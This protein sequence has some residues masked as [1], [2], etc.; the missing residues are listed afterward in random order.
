MT[1]NAPS[2]KR[3]SASTEP[4][5]I[6][7]EQAGASG[8]PEPESELAAA[9]TRQPAEPEVGVAPD[10]AA[11][12]TPAK[13]RRR[14]TKSAADQAPA[15]E[16]VVASE[17]TPVA[18]EPVV[19]A[20]ADVIAE[21]ATP[22][23]AESAPA[24]SKRSRKPAA[25]AAEPAPPPVDAVA[26]PAPEPPAAKPPKAR[27]SRSAKAAAAATAAR[28]AAGTPEVVPEADVHEPQSPTLEPEQPTLEP[29]PPTLRPAVGIP[30]F[31]RPATVAA[32]EPP[33][34]VGASPTLAV[35]AAAA[36]PEPLTEPEPITGAPRT[37]FEQRLAR[38]APEAAP[39]AA[40]AGSPTIGA[41]APLFDCPGCGRPLT[42]GTSRCPQCGT[43]LVGGRPLRR[44]GTIAAIGFVLVV[45][46][47][48]V[49]TAALAMSGPGPSV[50]GVVPP[51]T[52]P[53]GAPTPTP[54][55]AVATPTP[56]DIPPGAAA[57]LS[58]TTAVNTRI[59]V[60]RAALAAVLADRGAQTI[61]IARALRALA[62][63]AQLGLDMTGRLAPWTAAAAVTGQL[64]TFYRSLA[65]T[66]RDALRA[67]LTDEDGYRRAGALM[68][69]QTRALDEVD[70]ASRALAADVGLQLP[71]LGDPG[72][73]GSATPAS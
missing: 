67:S 61:D 18:G 10:P 39:V 71:P 31:E 62:A 70:A 64:D 23:E 4:E 1:S 28:V 37:K 53:S 33:A 50:G 2:R 42:K 49:M 56:L 58:G 46:L 27:T 9:S 63:D 36:T 73:G 60:D 8:T 16:A 15:P 6:P 29:D 26:Q 13:A 32:A 30:A 17:P 20:E 44:V 51:G 19:E 55:V 14:S 3:R 43:R 40:A 66:A 25:A 38:M 69:T 35:G 41:D 22:R 57:A 5:A 45:V 34:G 65:D 54:T 48:G 21:P 12:S 52:G 24:R 68:L 11:A 59:S 7:P 47:G 72:A